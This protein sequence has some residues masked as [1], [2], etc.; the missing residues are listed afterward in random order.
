MLARAALKV[1]DQNMNLIFDES[2]AA[3]KGRREYDEV[4]LDAR[5]AEFLKVVP[6]RIAEETAT[7]R[8]LLAAGAT[9]VVNGERNLVHDHACPSLRHQ[10]DRERAWREALPHILGSNRYSLNGPW[11]DQPKMPN[12]RTR[13]EVETLRRYE[14]CSICAPDTDTRRKRHHTDKYTL[15]TASKLARDHLGREVLDDRDQPLGTLNAFTLTVR[16]DSTDITLHIGEQLHPTQGATL[17]RLARRQ[18]SSG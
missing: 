3:W 15:V 17:I 10:M 12:L 6:S 8:E 1:E 9:Y 13:A 5:D 16:P 14:V 7:V 4:A 11:H 2:I 18:A